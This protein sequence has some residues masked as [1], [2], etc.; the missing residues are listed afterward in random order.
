MTSRSSNLIPE[1]DNEHQ[2]RVAQASCAQLGFCCKEVLL[3]AVRQRLALH[4]HFL[5][6]H[7]AGGLL[8]PACTFL[9]VKAVGGLCTSTVSKNCGLTFSNA[10]GFA[11]RSASRLSNLSL[12]SLTSRKPSV[13]VVGNN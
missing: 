4:D 9:R 11:S 2:L 12:L 5:G 3:Q 1:W 6:L 10:S 7:P 8:V 13:E